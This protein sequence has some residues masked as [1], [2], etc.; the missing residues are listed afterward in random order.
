MALD[1]IER[2]VDASQSEILMEVA[3]D[4]PIAFTMALHALAAVSAFMRIFVTSDALRI[5]RFILRHLNF[6]ASEGDVLISDGFMAFHA[7]HVSVFT[8]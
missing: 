7:L 5:D 1:A 2:V 8:A 3:S 4:F 6:F